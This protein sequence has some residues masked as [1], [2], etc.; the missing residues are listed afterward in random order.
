MQPQNAF[1]LTNVDY[2]TRRL[3]I[4]ASTSG[5]A[6]SSEKGTLS[7]VVLSYFKS[8]DFAIWYLTPLLY[9]SVSKHLPSRSYTNTVA[10]IRMLC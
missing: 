3:M 5:I 10:T 7:R 8:I 2:V 4:I 6:K 9:T 1:Y